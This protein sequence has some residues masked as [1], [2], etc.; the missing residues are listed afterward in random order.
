M[1]QNAS[2]SGPWPIPPQTLRLGA[3]A[4]CWKVFAVI[5]MPKGACNHC[6]ISH[7][8]LAEPRWTSL[9][10]AGTPCHRGN[11]CPDMSRHVPT[12]P[13][14]FRSSCYPCI[15]T[16]FQNTNGQVNSNLA[17]NHRWMVFQHVPTPTDGSG[18]LLLLKKSS[19]NL[20]CVAHRWSAAG[21]KVQEVA[22]IA[23]FF[24]L[25]Y[26][27]M[28]R[29]DW[30]FSIEKKRAT[31]IHIHRLAIPSALHG[32]PNDSDSDSCQKFWAFPL[33]TWFCLSPS[34]ILHLDVFSILADKFSDL[35][36]Q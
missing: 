12:C 23:K 14:C 22:G 26:V 10:F 28:L 27:F 6:G 1:S 8:T 17:N 35:Q 15:G 13:D 19:Q 18:N 9:E 16:T 29:P 31:W 5:S 7:W 11:S 34:N 32:F 21:W 25:S 2:N 24:D 36:L 20:S 33:V 30:A 4:V 3:L